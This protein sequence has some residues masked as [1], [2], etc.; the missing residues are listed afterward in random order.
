LTQQEPPPTD[1]RGL[2][3]ARRALINAYAAIN[4]ALAQELRYVGVDVPDDVEPYAQ[5]RQVADRVN[6]GERRAPH[7]LQLALAIMAVMA[8]PD[9]APPLDAQGAL[10]RVGAALAGE[11]DDI[12]GRTVRIVDALKRA[13]RLAPEQRWAF[14]YSVV[15]EALHSDVSKIREAWC[16]PELRSFD[17]EI[18]SRVETRLVVDEPRDLDELAFAVV[19]DNWSVCNDFFCSLQRLPERDATCPPTTGG[20]LRPVAG[21]W[22]GVYEERVGSCPSGWFPDTFLVFTWSMSDRQIILRYELTPRQPGDRTVLRIDQG[23]LQVD[24]VGAGYE[25]STVKYLLFDEEFI[26]GGGQTLGQSA[27]QLGWLDYSINQFTA[28]AD[29]AVLP[30]AGDG[31]GAGGMDADVQ[32]ILDRCEAHLV[33]SASETDAQ[34][35]RAIDRIRAG[36]YGPGEVAADWGHVLARVVRDGARSVRGQIDLAVSYADLVDGLVRRRR[37]QT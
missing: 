33:E 27:C 28:C 18:M 26:P 31:G 2:A 35:R 7:R 12:G 4:P 8:R 34:V 1:P 6:A 14:V 25:V 15:G 29:N 9:I 10:D 32:E 36:N 23:Y 21:D 17:G 22:R 24:R 16:R 30:F 3:P 5:L 19:P 13:A 11:G 37:D 20:N